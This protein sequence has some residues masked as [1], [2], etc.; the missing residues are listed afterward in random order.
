MLS[1]FL[2]RKIL[3]QLKGEQMFHLDA[4]VGRQALQ[5]AVKHVGEEHPY[6]VLQ[7]EL[8]DID[9]DDAFSSVP[10]EKGF[11]LL[12][13]LE[14][15]VGGDAVMNPFLRAYCQHFAY[16]TVTSQ[17]F[18]AFFLGYFQGKVDDAKLAG[19]DWD[20]WL[21]K[22]GMP[23]DPHF[24]RTLVNEAEALAK[25]WMTNPTS[26]QA[27]VPAPDVHKWDS[28]QVSQSS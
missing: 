12:Y 20:T 21:H 4:I 5:D 18:K 11:A 6:T 27:V 16:G 2:E 24:D 25:R 17:S 3:K 19:I 10:Y 23:P 13:H 8:K 7:V 9:P 28:D 22:P 26:A 14:Q 1:V 15:L